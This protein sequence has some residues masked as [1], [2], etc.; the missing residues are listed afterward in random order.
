[1]SRLRRQVGMRPHKGA[2]HQHTYYKTVPFHV[3]I[4]SKLTIGRQNYKKYFNCASFWAFFALFSVFC[5]IFITKKAAEAAL[6]V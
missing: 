1:M 4:T 2:T 5:K 6:F 3:P